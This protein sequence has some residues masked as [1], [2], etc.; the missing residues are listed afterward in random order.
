MVVGIDMYSFFIG[1]DRDNVYVGIIEFVRDQFMYLFWFDWIFE[2]NFEVMF[3]G[4]VDIL[5]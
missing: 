3:I 2:L 5:V 4:E 1:I